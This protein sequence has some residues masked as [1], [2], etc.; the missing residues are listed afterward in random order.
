MVWTSY[1]K[2]EK[3]CSIFELNTIRSVYNLGNLKHE[4]R[5]DSP[6]LWDLRSFSIEIRAPPEILQNI[7]SSLPTKAGSC[8][9]I[10]RHLWI[11]SK[12]NLSFFFFLWAIVSTAVEN[13]NSPPTIT[14]L[15]NIVH[16]SQPVPILALFPR[17]FVLEATLFFIRTS[18]CRSWQRC[19]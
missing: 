13:K 12:M 4:V 18:K 11:S 16:V 9:T 7:S 17:R 3:M 10:F 1:V 19:S 5:N 6:R 15:S 14:P 8:R 2:S